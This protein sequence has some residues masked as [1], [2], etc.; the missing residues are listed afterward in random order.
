[1]HRLKEFV[2]SRTGTLALAIIL[3]VVTALLVLGPAPLNPKN[4]SWLFGDAS[5]YYT[6]WALYRYDPHLHFP[7]PWTERIGYPIGGS[8]AMIDA[9][10]LVAVL[11]RP[12]SS[13]LPEPFQF[14]G[15]YALLCFVLQA[16]FGL[17]LARR[18]FPA[19]PAFAA[20]ASAFFLLSAPLT[21]R[22][23]GHTALVSHWLILAGFDSYFRA[24]D[25]HPARWLAPFWIVLAISAG[26]NSYLSVMCL[27]VTLAALARLVLERRCRWLQAL[28]LATVTVSVLLAS[29]ACVGVLVSADPSSFWAPG[30]GLFS[31]NLNSIVNPMEYGSILL[32]PLPVFH[33]GQVD[34]YNYLGL[35]IIFLLVLSL[36]R[37]PQSMAWLSERRLIPLVGLG[38]VSTALAL[39]ATVSF[40]SSALF[41]VPLPAAILKILNG[42]RA[43]GRFFWPAYYLLFIAAL[44]LTFHVWKAPA[45]FVILI[46]AVAV[47]FA[48]FA[49]LRA[50]VRA[51]NNQRYELPMTAPAWTDLGRKYD[52]LILIPPYQCDP[53]NGAGGQHSYVWFGRFAAAERMRLNSYYASRYTKPEL[54]GHCVELLREQLEG[55]LDPR[56]AYVVTDSVRTVWGLAGMRSHRCEAADVFTLCTP[57]AASDEAVRTPEIPAATRYALGTVLDFTTKGNARPYMTIG[58]RESLDTGTWTEGPMAMLRL[59]LDA[60]IDP[61]RTLV[62]EITSVPFVVERLH[63]RLLVDVVVNGQKLDEWLFRVGN[64]RPE[65]RVRIPAAL[66]AGRR[67]PGSLDIELRIR[68]PESPLYLGVGPWP[69]FLGLNV[70]RLTLQAE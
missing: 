4:V 3:G 45:R 47:Q 57:V 21:W 7:L 30:Y 59:G 9:V 37:R 65:R 38:L 10:P 42:L 68:N 34:G 2:Q 12:F 36:A 16:Y 63:P 29:A 52:N 27:L 11:L 49:T 56:S 43:S 48:D 54:F 61:A 51:T 50:S 39:S 69:A 58:W 55:R 15:L 14:L 6:A 31:L 5:S 1:M 25:E 23:F 24:L 8:V 41:T 62:L 22:A 66:A 64:A 70:Q 32:P 40:G 44:S 19:A 20:V 28:L 35:G 17:R 26:I 67:G 53:F 18:L 60:P 46:A 13:I 33:P